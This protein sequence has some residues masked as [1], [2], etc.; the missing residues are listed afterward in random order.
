M[1]DPSQESAGKF[2]EVNHVTGRLK[3]P[4]QEACAER[5]ITGRNHVAISQSRVPTFVRHYPK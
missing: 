2:Y 1:E 5:R 4:T 3:D